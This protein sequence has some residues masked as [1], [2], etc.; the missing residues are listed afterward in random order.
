[1]DDVQYH[2]GGARSIHDAEHARWVFESTYQVNWGPAPGSGLDTI[3]SFQQ[4]IEPKLEEVLGASFTTGCN[5]ILLG[6]AS[7][8]VT[9]PPELANIPFDS[10]YKPG[11]ETY[12][13]LD[14][15]TW[16]MGVEYVSG[17]PYVFSLSY[18][19]WEP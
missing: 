6:G 14:W 7:Y 19:A 8:V 9:W 13:G 5:Q 16:L 1:M 10:L 12:G 17:K 15:Q 2:R 18:Y 4:I 3:G 11:T